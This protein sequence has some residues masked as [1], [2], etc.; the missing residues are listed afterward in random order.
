MV[1]V[2][3]VLR[4]QAA[5]NG[6]ADVRS[7]SVIVMD[8]KYIKQTQG[9]RKEPPGFETFVVSLSSER[10]SAVTAFTTSDY[11]VTL[12]LHSHSPEV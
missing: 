4:H 10:R 11:D 3:E 5:L 9:S 1:L 8:D 6:T 12:P 2:V 7:L